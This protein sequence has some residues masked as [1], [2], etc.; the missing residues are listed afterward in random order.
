MSLPNVTPKIDPLVS[1]LF[2]S[3]GYAI[4]SLQDWNPQNKLYL[5]LMGNHS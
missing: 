4:Y 1:A 5:I 3:I 2:K